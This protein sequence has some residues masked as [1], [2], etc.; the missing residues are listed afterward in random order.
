[1]KLFLL[2]HAVESHEPEE[3]I[4]NSDSG[5]QL[6]ADSCTVH[7]LLKPRAADGQ[8]GQC[9]FALERKD[10]IGN[11]TLELMK[12]L[13]RQGAATRMVAKVD[14]ASYTRFEARSVGFKVD[15]GAT[16]RPAS[17]GLGV[18]RV[19]LSRR[20]FFVGGLHGFFVLGVN[21]PSVAMIIIPSRK[22]SFT[23]SISLLRPR[24][25]RRQ[26]T[27]GVPPPCWR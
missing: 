23:R 22:R 17:V 3:Q 27:F 21:S 12:S 5:I 13:V 8:T 18:M 16:H 1:M 7:L 9:C 6:D 10:F 25:I 15:G 24:L 11:K 2:A 4:H 14:R 20:L 19:F 26:A